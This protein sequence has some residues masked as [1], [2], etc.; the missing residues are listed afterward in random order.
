[1]QV[2]QAPKAP[3]GPKKMFNKVKSFFS[4][5]GEPPL[6]LPEP[7]DGPASIDERDA[8]PTMSQ[9]DEVVRPSSYADDPAVSGES[10]RR[11]APEPTGEAAARM[12]AN[13]SFYGRMVR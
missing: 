11:A 10:V 8:P 13:E 12:S 7:T 2:E 3:S 4:F 9:R 6:E 5:G 1:M